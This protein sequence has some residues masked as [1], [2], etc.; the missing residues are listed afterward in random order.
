MPRPSFSKILNLLAEIKGSMTYKAPIYTHEVGLEFPGREIP[1]CIVQSG[2]AATIVWSQFHTKHTRDAKCYEFGAAAVEFLGFC[3]DHGVRDL[4]NITSRATHD[5][6]EKLDH[7]FVQHDQILARLCALQIFFSM[8]VAE[9][10]MQRPL[11]SYWTSGYHIPPKLI[12]ESGRQEQEFESSSAYMTSADLGRDE[13]PKATF[14]SAYVQSLAKHTNRQTQDAYYFGLKR[15]FDYLESTR[16]QDILHV[17]GHHFGGFIRSLETVTETGLTDARAQTVRSSMAAVRGLFD[18]FI[19][20]GLLKTNIAK[21]VDLPK[22]AREKGTTPVLTG[23]TFNEIIDA[24]PLLTHADYR[25]RALIALMGYSLFRISAAL[26]MQVSDYFIRGDIRYLKSTEKRTKSHE[27]P[28]HDVLK[29]YID[30][31]LLHTGLID[32]PDAPLFQGSTPHGGHLKGRAF[33][34]NAALRMV[35]RRARAANYFGPVGNHSFR[36]TGIT[37]YLAKGGELEEAR[38]MAGHK[39]AETT[40][41]Y[42]RNVDLVDLDEVNRIEF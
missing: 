15:F 39:S 20:E 5:Y 21:S 37:N 42:N 8:C 19:V 17:S 14:L 34:R 11:L 38:K 36:A 28:V 25:D 16:L 4:R 40:R 41:L 32:Q 22:I 2:Q 9:G 33:T 26:R 23:E 3:E 18:Q 35:K 30:D 10:L 12:V 27:M 7:A 13:P 29:H 31:Y 24:I 6:I 1:R